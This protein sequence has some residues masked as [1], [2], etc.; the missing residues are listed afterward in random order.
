M[1]SWVRSDEVLAR[2]RRGPWAIGLREGALHIRSLPGCEH[3]IGLADTAGRVEWDGLSAD[4]ASI[5]ITTPR[6]VRLWV[7]QGGAFT[8]LQW[9]GH[10]T[11]AHVA[12]SLRRRFTAVFVMAVFWLIAPL[13]VPAGRFESAL[14]IDGPM[15]TTAFAALILAY[16][17]AIRFRPRRSLFLLGAIYCSAL[18]LLCGVNAFV[19]DVL[20]GWLFAVA[21]MQLAVTQFR[22]FVFFDSVDRIDVA[23]RNVLQG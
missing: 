8:L 3:I 1:A 7:E 13:F 19:G 11:R 14:R 10:P 21:A 16:G 2:G 18:A 6:H 17:L 12:A 4:S 23:P 5:L 9:I 22:M 20:W 15:V